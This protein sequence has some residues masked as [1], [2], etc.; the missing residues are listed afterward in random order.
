LRVDKGDRAQRRP[1]EESMNATVKGRPGSATVSGLKF[2]PTLVPTALSS[3]ASSEAS[4]S[5]D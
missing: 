3:R 4:G 1:I 5:E 2:A